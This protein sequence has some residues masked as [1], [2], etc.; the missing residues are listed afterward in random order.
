MHWGCWDPKTEMIIPDALIPYSE[1]ILSWQMLANENLISFGGI[2]LGNTL[3]L[4]VSVVPRSRWP[5]EGELSS[6]SSISLS[7]NVLWWLFLFKFLKL[8]YMVFN[9]FSMV[10]FFFFSPIPPPPGPLNI[11][12]GFQFNVFTRFLSVTS[13]GLFLALLLQFVL[14]GSIVLVL[15]LSFILLSHSRM[16]VF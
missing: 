11:H 7:Y 5:R 12:D 13:H 16:S 1:A 2:A 9:L 3:I 10:F 14:S 6:S 15:F 4:G 8:P